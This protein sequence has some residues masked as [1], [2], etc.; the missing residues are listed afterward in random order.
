MLFFFARN[1]V[2]SKNSHLDA[3]MGGGMQM[4]S[5]VDKMLYRVAGFTAEFDGKDYFV[6]FRNVKSFREADHYLRVM[7][8]NERLEEVALQIEA[9][10]WT[11]DTVADQITDV[12]GQNETAIPIGDIKV[13]SVAVFKTQYDMTTNTISLKPINKYVTPH[14]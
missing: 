10:Q 14:D 7:P 12:G 3:W 13:K 1:L 9:A 5:S 6:N 4:F 8:S 11:I 2:L